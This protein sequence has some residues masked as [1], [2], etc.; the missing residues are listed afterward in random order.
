MVPRDGLS[1]PTTFRCACCVVFICGWPF[2]P[3]VDAVASGPGT[4]APSTTGFIKPFQSVSY[5]LPPAAPRGFNPD[6]GSAAPPSWDDPLEGSRYRLRFDRVETSVEPPAA[7]PVFNPDP[8]AGSRTNLVEPSFFQR[9][10]GVALAY[11]GDPVPSELALPR[12]PLTRPQRQVVPPA[13]G[14]SH[15][16]ASLPE[17]LELPRWFV[18][19]NRKIETDWHNPH[20]TSDADESTLPPNTTPVP[21]RWKLGFAP[22]RR[23]T[24]GS[25]GQPYASDAPRL[26]H[27]YKQSYLKGDLPIIG[28]D[29]FLNLTASSITELELR[30]LPT[31]SAISAA[32]PG[33][34]EFYGRSE[35]LG[36][37]QYFG[38]A[39]E[40]FEGEAAFKP[41]HWAIKLQ[42]VLNFNYT[43]VSEN[44]AVN[45]D[46]RGTGT[47][48]NTPPPPN[49]FVTDPGDIDALLGGQLGVPPEDLAGR[50][51]TTRSEHFIALQEWFAEIHLGDLS[52]NYDFYAF[53]V[54]SQV[55]NSDFRGFLFNDV[56]TG[57]RLFGNYGNNHL[58]YNVALFDLREKDT[59][60]ELNTFDRRDQMVFIANLYRQDFLWKGYTAQLSF[61]ANLDRG[62]VHY[63]ENHNIARPAPLGTVRRHDVDAYYFGWAGDGH[64]GRWN[65]SHAFYQAFGRDEFNGLAGQ[66]ADINAQF[67]AAEL[68]Y[69]QDWIRYKASVVYASGDHSPE[70]G[71]AT[72]FDVIFDNP[73]F[74]GGPFSYW[75]RQG[76]NL[77]GSAVLLKQRRSLVPS[78]R[79]SKAEGQ[80]NF[81]N[82]GIFMIGVGTE[83]ELTPRVRGFVDANYVRLVTAEPIQTALLTQRIDEEIGVDLSMGVQWRPLL[84]DNLI[85]SAGLGVLLPGEGFR[86]IYR[87]T[88]EPVP[89]FT[90][91]SGA[92]KTDDFLYSALLAVTLTY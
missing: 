29:V 30:R 39:A 76:F 69:D 91:G 61:H 42:P 32:R 17:H 63:D 44:N 35:Q 57:A 67:A 55:F 50:R 11:D 13:P 62:G 10:F 21:D 14:A 5:D 89:G 20:F 6:P 41:F 85:V 47:K 74:T 40:L 23:Y 28:Q 73:N 86:D 79:T 31:P 46:P 38:F 8:G 25:T 52:D 82:P 2:I 43:E 59:N 1:S 3:V 9:E 56:N 37:Q 54:G 4:P 87:Q 68:S 36:L 84:T 92:G 53:R 34:A 64:I 48:D 33:S 7:P 22:W 83:I 45:A 18:R 71:R 88:T 80:A 51:H 65:L 75:V 60:S 15:G 26:W 49:D 66:P 77:G 27:P 58:Q 12:G 70:D 24:S 19:S 90:T 81:V 78:M 16:G 72:G